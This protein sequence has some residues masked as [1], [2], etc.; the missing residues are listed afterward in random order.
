MDVPVKDEEHGA[1]DEAADE[2]QKEE[3]RHCDRGSPSDLMPTTR[4]RGGLIYEILE[5]IGPPRPN[6]D[7]P[8]PCPYFPILFDTTGGPR[9]KT[10]A[11][12]FFPPLH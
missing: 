3:K 1:D 4:L 11:P 12:L 6:K 7:N 9:P 8:T 5:L 2:T 10:V